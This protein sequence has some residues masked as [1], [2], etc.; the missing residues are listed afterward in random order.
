MYRIFTTTDQSYS[1][2]KSSSPITCQSQNRI[3][4]VTQLGEKKSVRKQTKKQNQTNTMSYVSGRFFE[5]CSTLTLV[6]FVT[7]Y[8]HQTTTKVI[9]HRA[10]HHNRAI[11]HKATHHSKVIH[12]KAMATHHR[13][14]HHNKAIHQ[15]H[16]TAIHHSNQ[17][18]HTKLLLVRPSTFAA[19]QTVLSSMVR[20][21]V[22]LRF[23]THIC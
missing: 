17:W 9:H 8:S 16:N 14:I 6:F 20:F 1:W 18:I 7:R 5:Q 2:L 3:K 22:L 11:L 10:T 23:C 13:A 12:H 4:T 15:C 19:R 21:F